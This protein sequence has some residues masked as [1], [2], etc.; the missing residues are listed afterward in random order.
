MNGPPEEV[1]RRNSLLTTFYHSKDKNASG[2]ARNFNIFQ[3]LFS[4]PAT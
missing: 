2:K 1:V 4:A 3:A